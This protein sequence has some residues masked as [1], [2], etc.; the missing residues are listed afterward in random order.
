MSE[1]TE[2]E[3]KDL[4]GQKRPSS[5][6]GRDRR[7]LIAAVGALL[8]GWSSS[9]ADDPDD[10]IEMATDVIDHYD[11]DGYSLAKML[12]DS[13][14]LS[15]DTELVNELDTV[16]G[17]KRTAHKAS[18]KR[19][20]EENAIKCPFKIGSIVRTDSVKGGTGE[21]YEINESEATCCVRFE[22]LGHVKSGTG[23]HGK[24]LKYEE[25]LEVIP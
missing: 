24:I 6:C 22:R 8:T 14:F 13:Y 10:L 17:L 4:A 15:P 19:W 12:E 9:C 25:M 7:D 5:A 23:T 16:L 2:L 3:I 1:Q 11:D 21:V 20:V 18:I